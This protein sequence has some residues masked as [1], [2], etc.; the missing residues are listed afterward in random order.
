MLKFKDASDRYGLTS[1]FGW[2]DAIMIGASA[3]G[4]LG[5]KSASSS[6]AKASDR[7]TESNNQLA[8]ELYG[9]NSANFQPYIQSG[10]QGNQAVTN[11]LG[12][13]GQPAGGGPGGGASGGAGGGGQTG[14]DGASYL[15]QNP[16]VAAEY[17]KSH[18]PGLAQ[19]LG[20][21][22]DKNADL[23]PEQFAAWHYQNFGQTEGRQAPMY[24]PQQQ[25][26]ATPPTSGTGSGASPIPDQDVLG[27]MSGQR[28]TYERP[29][30]GERPAMARGEMAPL[31]VGLDQ[32]VE[33][34]D[35]QFQMG[36][37]IGSIMSNKTL[38]SGIRTGGALKSVLDFSQ[39]LAM[40]DYGQWRDYTTGQYNVDRSRMDSLDNF[41]ASRS[42][43]NYNF[44]VNRTDTNFLNDRAFGTG[45]WEADRGYNTSRY[46]QRT[47]DLFRLS[48]QG[49][50]AAG[51]LSG[52]SQNYL[53]NVTSNNNTQA[54]VTANAALTGASQ[55]NNLFGDLA[56]YYGQRGSSYGG[57]AQGGYG[58]NAGY[59]GARA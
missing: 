11:W 35:L 16:D 6:A 46:D 52:A 19:G 58:Y 30:V 18:G 7:A 42:D 38:G 8:R 49:L 1:I 55:V 34:P 37:G 28:P 44:G 57:G 40:G 9:Q 48:G 45:T 29:E 15:Q 10:Y 17:A 14:F 20:L 4:F 50:Q 5:S 56:Q 51:S 23:T 13:G 59:G 24:A 43:A 27:P 2:D 54:G 36:R 41:D 53:G 47:N 31:D 12:V 26:A 33:S 32:Y 39:N 21:S 3:L 25:A 22:K